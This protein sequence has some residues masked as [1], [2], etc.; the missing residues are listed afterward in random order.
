VG[1]AVSAGTKASDW[2]S[3]N[4]ATLGVKTVVVIGASGFIGE[5]LLAVLAGHKDI[6]VRVLMHRTRAKSQA[7]INYIE[8]DLLKPDSLD[9]LLSNNCTVINLAYLAQNNLEAITNLANACVKNKIRRLIHCS[10][11]AV[12]GRT[13]SD[14]V[15]ETTMCHP[16]SEYQRTKLQ[17][18]AILLE[19]TVDRF[20]VTILRPTAVFGLYGKN[21]LKLANELLTGNMWTNYLRSCLF[22][23]RSMNLVAVENVV[24]ALVFLLDAEKVD[25]EIFIIS[26]DGSAE[27]NYRDVENRLLTAFGMHYHISRLPVPAF[28]LSVL[29]RMAGRSNTNPSIIYG[30]KKLA[31]LG[32]DKPQNIEK[33]IDA[34]ATWYKNSC[35]AKKTG[36]L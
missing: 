5:H 23:R 16:V 32:F 26:D 10:T 20:E 29:L 2:M 17:I 28:I 33:A 27:N 6:E 12:V 34:F 18:E 1:I 9:V 13:K 7:N 25:R 15:D 31:A 4:R 14:F 21:L 36:H 3:I 30:D 11:A 24:A 8:G 35:D 22:N 19:M